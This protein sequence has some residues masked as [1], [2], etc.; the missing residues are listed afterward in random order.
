M[1]PKTPMKEVN[2]GGH[3]YTTAVTTPRECDRHATYDESKMVSKRLT[4]LKEINRSRQRN[5]VFTGKKD[6]RRKA[7]IS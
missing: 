1:I 7:K 3:W 5:E 4:D 6:H 2:E